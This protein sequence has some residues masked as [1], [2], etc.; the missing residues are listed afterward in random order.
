MSDG[1]TGDN[2]K[3]QCAACDGAGWIE[4]VTQ[5]CCGRTFPSGE[6]RGECSVAEQLQ[7][8][9]AVCNGSGQP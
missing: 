9:C 5:A 2:L 1:L 4:G 8:Q 3:S 6:C 7:E